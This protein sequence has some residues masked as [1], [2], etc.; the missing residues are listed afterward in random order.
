M[1]L[2]KLP[3]K[4]DGPVV[5]ADGVHFRPLAASGRPSS[6]ASTGSAW[7][8]PSP[9]PPT[10]SSACRSSWE[11]PHDR[12][13]RSGHLDGHEVHSHSGKITHRDHKPPAIAIRQ[14]NNS[15]P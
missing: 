14:S 7:P 2:A 6:A 4:N 15:A 10:T 1:E 9:S 3:I 12:S 11:K 13:H 8:S 5:P